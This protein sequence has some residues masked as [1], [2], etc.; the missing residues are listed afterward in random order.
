MLLGYKLYTEMVTAYANSVL[1]ENPIT[2]EE[3]WNKLING[4]EFELDFNGE[5]ITEY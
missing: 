3:K 1:T 2:L 4:A 5:T